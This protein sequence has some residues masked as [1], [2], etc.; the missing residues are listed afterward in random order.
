VTAAPKLRPG[1]DEAVGLALFEI[2]KVGR[3]GHAVGRSVEQ[4]IKVRKGKA[5][6]VNNLNINELWASLS[7]GGRV[8]ILLMRLLQRV[9][10]LFL[11]IVNAM[12]KPLEQE[13]RTFERER[14]HLEREHSGKFVLI[15]GEDVIGT[16]DGFEAAANEGL[17]RFGSSPFLIREIGQRE[18]QLSPAVLY[19]LT[20][21]HL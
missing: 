21:A 10:R 5:L 9:F 17:R 7:W 3:G 2:I 18:I 19:G 11:P 1:V 6:V 4:G 12:T 20:G 13:L 16:Y 14:S 15:H 8:A